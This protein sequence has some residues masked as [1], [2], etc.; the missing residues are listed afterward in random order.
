MTAAAKPQSFNKVKSKSELN[1]KHQSKP[2]RPENHIDQENIKGNSTFIET[3][4][5]YDPVSIEHTK[6]RNKH[7]MKQILKKSQQKLA[8]MLDSHRNTLS[9]N[10]SQSMINLNAETPGNGGINES[11]LR[12]FADVDEHNNKGEQIQ[13]HQQ[14]TNADV[15]VSASLIIGR[16]SSEA[17]PQSTFQMMK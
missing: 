9:N 2:Q 6:Y 4:S 13:L 16:E 7:S 1:R 14:T 10:T 12:H 17:Q 15:S 5:A 11:S 3:K 8:Q